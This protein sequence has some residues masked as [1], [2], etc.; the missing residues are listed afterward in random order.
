MTVSSFTSL[1]LEPPLVLVSL[2]KSTRTHDLVTR[3][4]AFA[5]T[6]LSEEQEAVSNRFAGKDT[7]N[8]NRYTG[9]ETFTLET[10]SPLLAEGLAFFDCRVV[11]QYDAGTNTVMIGEVVAAQANPDG[12]KIPPLVY[13]NRD[14]RKLSD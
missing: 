9:L 4:K 7:E 12:D 14:Y 3:S 6:L 2:H 11:S 1:S 5:V 10:G 13:F 8:D